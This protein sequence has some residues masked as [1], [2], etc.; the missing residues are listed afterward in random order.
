MSVV[1]GESLLPPDSSFL[2]DGSDHPGPNG[3]V[4]F[5]EKLRSSAEL[6]LNQN[7]SSEA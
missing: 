6:A 5:Y 4:A 1:N 2:I 3:Q 7:T